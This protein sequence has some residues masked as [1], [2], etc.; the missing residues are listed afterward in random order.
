MDFS[1]NSVFPLGSPSADLPTPLSL[2]I[3][4]PTLLSS[5]PP[6]LQGSLTILA[7][8]TPRPPFVLLIKRAMLSPL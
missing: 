2:L 1:R 6:G 5:H 3:V 7:P 4:T 8:R